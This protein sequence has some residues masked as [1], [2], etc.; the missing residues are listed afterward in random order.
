MSNE[1]TKYP[2]G[3][4]YKMPGKLIRQFI[5]DPIKTLSTISQK[6]G[7]ISYF[8]LGPKQHVYLINNPDYIEKVLIYDHRNFKK[9]KRLQAAKALLGEGLVTSEGDFHNRQRRLIQPIFHPKQIMAYGKIM[10]DYAIRL[11]DR[12]KNEDILDISEEMMQL[13]LGIICKSVLNYDVESEA[14]Q[15]GKALTTTRNYSKRLQSPIG[16]V[17]DKIPILPAPMGAREAKKELDSL[18]YRLIS[19]RRRHQQES[20]NDDDNKNGND[21]LLSRLLQAQDSNLAGPASSNG[22][23]QSSSS[24]TSPDGKMSDKQVRDEVMTIFIAGHE[25]TANALTWTFYLLSQ[26]PDVEKKLHDEIDSVLGAIDDDINGHDDSKKIPT[27][28]DI[29]KLQYTEKV[30]RES[31]RLYPPVWTMGRYVENDYH[32]GEYTIPAGSSI[33]MSQY[34]MHH[35]PRYYEEPEHF[36]PDRWTAKF[37]TDLPRF[38]YF[39]FGG[40][41]RGCVGEPFAWMEGILIIATIAQNWTMHLIPGQRIKLDPAIT[42]RPKYG[43]KMKLI[44]RKS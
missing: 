14:K 34:V 23:A 20:D 11:R 15:V 42:L 43:M 30:L 35:D 13:T 4:T 39:P 8:K 27:V 21:D 12:W 5:H 28:V 33:L 32:V 16:Q 7:D 18:V 9:G 22:G 26:Y 1:I 31:M 36:N 25:T 44:R 41:I 38:S 29:P 24:S 17:L 6:Y 40:G 2:P 19:D 10:T 3:P 37:K